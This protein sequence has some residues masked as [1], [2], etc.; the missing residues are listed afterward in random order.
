[1]TLRLPV[2][3]FALFTLFLLTIAWPDSLLASPARCGVILPL[4]GPLASIG[5][6]IKNSMLLSQEKLKSESVVTFIFEDDQFVPRN[7]V[8]LVNR[9][10]DLDRVSCL[11]VFGSTTSLSVV[12]IVERNALPTI[13]IAIT[14]KVALSKKYVVRH[15]ILASSQAE[16]IVGQVNKLGYSDLAILSTQQD[17]ALALRE[18]FLKL[19]TKK[20]LLDEQLLPGDTDCRALAL[21]VK[22][23]APPALM[24]NLLP[25]QASIC[26]KQLRQSGYRGDFFSGPFLGNRAEIA[27]AQGTLDRAWFVS[28]DDSKASEFYQDYFK[29]F[30]NAPEIEATNGYDIIRLIV[31][32][33][34][35]HDLNHYLHTVTNFSGILGQYSALD[36]TFDIPVGMHRVVNGNI[37]AL[38]DKN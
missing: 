3:H 18:H 14:P 35:S 34:R 36:N 26:S 17:A 12:D 11:V 15:Y 24:L 25:P 8:T 33:L 23:L 6:S 16:K 1:M 31:E 4:T 32:G 29:R 22:T 2:F 5:S 38:T 20:P 10:I 30:G 13:A 9:L 7:T 28:N 27:A 19:W 21:K 37:E